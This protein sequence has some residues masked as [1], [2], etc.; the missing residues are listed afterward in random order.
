MEPYLSFL[1]HHWMLSFAFI[2]VLISVILFELYLQSKGPKRL[3][4]QAVVLLMNHDNAL[5]VDLRDRAL[6]AKGHIVNSVNALSSELDRGVAKLKEHQCSP[7]I[8]VGVSDQQAMQA[9]E[10]LLKQG[11][12]DVRLLSG[13]IKAWKDA[14]LPLEGK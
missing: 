12:E 13:G 1:T 6:F 11:F 4:P 10:K 14:S 3:D 5:V 7:I 2:V 8:L 9:A